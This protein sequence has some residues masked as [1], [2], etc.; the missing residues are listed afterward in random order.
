M[1]FINTPNAISTTII[2]FTTLLVIIYN[3]QSPEYLARRRARFAISM[4]L[5][6]EH[7][8]LIENVHITC[9]D[10]EKLFFR[11]LL[12]SRYGIF[13]INTCHYRGE[14]FGSHHQ[15]RWLSRSRIHRK[16]F[17]NPHMVNEEIVKKLAE[18]LYIPPKSCSTLLVF[19]G[20][21]YFPTHTPTDTC[22][23]KELIPTINQRNKF[24]IKA[25]VLPWIVEVLKLKPAVVDSHIE[26]NQ[27]LVN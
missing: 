21:S 3:R 22:R 4:F 15:V 26:E 13:I 14:I 24:K 9:R 17:K 2:L 23:V 18:Y 5:F 1:D 10:G 20:S 11:Q 25:H 7:Y 12:V 27:L 8:E 19:T 16:T 6:K